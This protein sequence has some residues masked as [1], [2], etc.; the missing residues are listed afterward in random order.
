MPEVEANGVQPTPAQGQLDWSKLAASLGANSVEE[1]QRRAYDIAKFVA[2]V[3]NDSES[4]LI[5]KTGRKQMELNL[6]K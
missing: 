4:Q 1:A 6:N 2:D 5:L 3:E